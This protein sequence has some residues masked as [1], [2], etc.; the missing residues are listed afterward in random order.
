M[1]KKIYSLKEGDEESKK[2]YEQRLNLTLMK[3]E[4]FYFYNG[5]R[6]NML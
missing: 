4:I 6:V 5:I 1:L 3:L 2:A